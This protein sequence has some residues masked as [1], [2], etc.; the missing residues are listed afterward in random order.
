MPE[1]KWMLMDPRQKLEFQD[2]H[3]DLVIDKSEV[4]ANMRSGHRP[5]LH[6]AKVLSEL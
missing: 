6:A 2:N 5:F 1:V 3:F 4:D